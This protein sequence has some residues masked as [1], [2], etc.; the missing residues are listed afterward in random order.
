MSVNRDIGREGRE[1][2]LSAA[3]VRLPLGSKTPGSL[4]AGARWGFLVNPNPGAPCS[5]RG[6]T[7]TGVSGYH[8]LPRP[9]PAPPPPPRRGP[10]GVAAQLC[11][12]PSI[13]LRPIPLGSAL[14]GR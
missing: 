2:P 13:L 4:T 3:K 14:P 12:F 7:R 8:L 6:D 11:C 5:L 10:R 1:E 9:R